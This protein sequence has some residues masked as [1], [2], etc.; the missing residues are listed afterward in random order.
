MVTTKRQVVAVVSGSVSTLTISN[1]GQ[2]NALTP[3]MLDQLGQFIAQFDS[4]PDIRT[5]VIR[6]EGGVFSSGYA[7]DTF[8]KPDDLEDEDELSR[9]VG[10]LRCCATPSLAVIDGDAIGAGLHLALGADIRIATSRSRLGITPARFAIIYPR[11]GIELLAQTVGLS[12]A[13]RLLITGELLD[14]ESG[15]RAGLVDEV[16]EDSIEPVVQNWQAR[17]SAASPQSVSG[18]KWLLSRIG[19]GG[20]SP[21]VNEA[22]LTMRRTALASDDAAEARL[23]FNERRAPRFTGA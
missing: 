9:A 10:A 13:R 17:L 15:W 20:T 2:R 12:F 4:D 5:I 11:Q 3:Q 19:S 23:A 18:T 7:L 21:E 16:T 14:A 22:F 1:P 6:G 8:P